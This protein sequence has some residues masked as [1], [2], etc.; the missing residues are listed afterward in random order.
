MGVKFRFEI[1]V[2]GFGKGIVSYV[3]GIGGVKIQK[4]IRYRISRIVGDLE[5]KLLEL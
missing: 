3:F 2:E 4:V 1:F 5:I